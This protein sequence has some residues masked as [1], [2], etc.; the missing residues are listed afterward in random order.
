M[1]NQSVLSPLM[2]RM[3]KMVVNIGKPKVSS[4]AK[5]TAA[6]LQTVSQPLGLEDSSF[7]TPE[8]TLGHIFQLMV[9]N[10]GMREMDHIDD[11]KRLDRKNRD[12]ESRHKEI[13]K[14][15]TI[16]R[17]PKKKKVKEE[18]P[19]EKPK[20]KVE[21]PTPTPSPTPPTPTPT[22]PPAVPPKAPPTTTPPKA[23]PTATPTVSTS[24]VPTAVKVGV[25]V[26]AAGT[27]ATAIGG[28]ES[29][30]NYDITFGDRVDKSGK[31]VNQKGF[32]TPES[33]YG[34]KLTNLT[35]AQVD[36]L[37]KYR[38]SKSP[39]SSAMG[40]YQFMNSTLFGR[41]DKNGKLIPGLVQQLKLDMDTKFTPEVQDKLY[42]LLHDNDIATLKRLGVPITP[43]YEYMAHYIGAGG[44]AAVHSR[45]N[46]N[47]TVAEAMADAKLT[48]PG[49]ENNPELYTIKTSEF[50]KVLESRLNKHGLSSP[51]SSNVGEKVTQTSVENENIRRQLNEKSDVNNVLNN[52][53]INAQSPQQGSNSPAVNDKSAM[54]NKKNNK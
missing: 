26:A 41:T 25:G 10:D 37:G 35:L 1:E 11:L 23:P 19:K 38:N 5:N 14:A 9:E 29:G 31:I 21:E 7:S 27:A 32:E 50:E 4:Q 53:V 36:E 48:P 54:E 40:K 52:T 39:N 28:A 8:Q 2:D 15:L 44:A 51:H 42:K 24:K 18:K 17:P 45:I 12:E 47:M 20:K 16:R 33:R 13:L 30:G 43:G 46:Q 49:K 3:S 6:A 34:T 22:T